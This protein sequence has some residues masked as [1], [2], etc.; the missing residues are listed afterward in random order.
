M[1]RFYTHYWVYDFSMGIFHQ[2]TWTIRV[3]SLAPPAYGLKLGKCEMSE[4]MAERLTFG[5]TSTLL[6]CACGRIEVREML[7]APTAAKQQ[8]K[9][10]A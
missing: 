2:H 1:L 3:E 5:V 8:S 10:P 7:G 4:H 6:T 9:V